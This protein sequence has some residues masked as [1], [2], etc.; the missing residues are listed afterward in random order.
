LHFHFYLHQYENVSF[1]ESKLAGATKYCINLSELPLENWANKLASVPRHQLVEL[2]SQIRDRQFTEV[3]Q[4]YLHK[5]GEITFGAIQIIPPV[6]GGA[7]G[8][9][10]VQT[11]TE[12]D[13]LEQL[14]FRGPKI[15]MADGPMPGNVKHFKTLHLRFAY[16]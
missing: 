10:M 11:E 13:P 4:F 8:R 1:L 9:P 2:V 14:I 12:E 16:L 6:V 5:V 15:D 7:F 3:I